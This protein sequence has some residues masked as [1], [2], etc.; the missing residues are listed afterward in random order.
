MKKIFL[1]A[2]VL[3]AVT[4]CINNNERKA[5]KLIKKHLKATMNDYSSYESMGFGSLD[6][7]FSKFEDTK[8]YEGSV[9]AIESS[10]GQIEFYKKQVI[11]RNNSFFKTYLEKEE[12]RYSELKDELIKER[13]SYKGNFL[14]WHMSHQFRGANAFGGKIIGIMT[15]Y[16]DK[17]MSSVIDVVDLA[18]NSRNAT[19]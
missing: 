12:I 6:S 9:M 11:E 17:D 19:E 5:K 7:T 2:I 4:S 3:L 13:S 16:F 14:G 15:F 18:E 10:K 8:E 1:L